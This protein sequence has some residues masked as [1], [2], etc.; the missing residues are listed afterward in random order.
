MNDS[1]GSGSKVIISENN[2]C[3]N[4]NAETEQKEDVPSHMKVI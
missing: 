2:A 3:P 1:K 4:V